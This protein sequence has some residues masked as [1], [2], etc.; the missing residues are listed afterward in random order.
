MTRGAKV[1]L[2][3]LVLCLAV[4]SVAFHFFLQGAWCGYFN[5]GPSETQRDYCVSMV[6]DT[7]RGLII[8][9][10]PAAALLL[11]AIG[12]LFARSGRVAVACWCAGLLLAGIIFFTVPFVTVGGHEVPLL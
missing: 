4:A 11:G 12:A 2:G 1:G 6:R 7:S 3:V 8:A 10:M 5:G 9:S